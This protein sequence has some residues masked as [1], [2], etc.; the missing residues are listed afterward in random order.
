MGDAIRNYTDKYIF[1]E[2][3]SERS[4]IQAGLRDL[5]HGCFHFIGGVVNS[6]AGNK[7][8]ADEDFQRCGDHFGGENLKQISKE[9]RDRSS[10]RKM[11]VVRAMNEPDTFN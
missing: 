11:Q 6:V 4:S 2:D 5:S 9:R 7:E 3:P 1:G 10:E 8:K